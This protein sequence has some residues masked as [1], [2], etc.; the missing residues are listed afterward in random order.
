MINCLNYFPLF[1]QHLSLVAMQQIYTISML[2]IR[3]IISWE[4]WYPGLA[5]PNPDP[6]QE[7]HF[8]SIDCYCCILGDWNCNDETNRP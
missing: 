1:Y 3:N 7:S 4:N 2:I 8:Q 5:S 6:I